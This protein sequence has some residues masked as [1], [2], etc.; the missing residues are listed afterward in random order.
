[1]KDHLKKTINFNLSN[2][3]LDKDYFK[4]NL[5]LSVNKDGFLSID[6]IK[7]D[8]IFNSEINKAVKSFPA[9][10]KPSL[11]NNNFNEYKLNINFN[12]KK[13][14]IPNSEKFDNSFDSIFKPNSSNKFSKYFS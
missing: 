2:E 6:K 3:V 14:K 7:A 10:S 13:G 8:N 5:N 9:F 1:M 4:I 12:F 11:K